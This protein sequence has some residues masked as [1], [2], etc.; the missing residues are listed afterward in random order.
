MNTAAQLSAVMDW[1]YDD[2]QP[3]NFRSTTIYGIRDFYTR[4]GYF[5]TNQARTIAN[6][7][8]KYRI[9]VV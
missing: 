1:L 2:K 8:L 4:T 6:T 3:I 9:I 5:T 7:V